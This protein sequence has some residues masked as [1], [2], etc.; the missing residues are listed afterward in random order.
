MSCILW[1]LSENPINYG[2]FTGCT[3]MGKGHRTKGGGR[4]WRIQD[5]PKEGAPT[6][7][8]VPTYDIAKISQK[9]HEIERIWTPGGGTRPKFYYV[10]PPLAGDSNLHFTPE[11]SFNFKQ[12]T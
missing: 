12:L 5:F 6:L 9:L 11:K 8:G 7:R 1:D 2:K 4:Q 10:D 3:P